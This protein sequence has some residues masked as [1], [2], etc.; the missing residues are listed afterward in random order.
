[1]LKQRRSLG[2][3][4]GK[5]LAALVIVGLWQLLTLIVSGIELP[6]AREIVSLL[7]EPGNALWFHGLISARRILVSLGIALVLA[8]PLGM[9]LGRNLEVDRVVGPFI[10]LTYPVPKLVFLPLVFVLLGLGDSSRVLLI[11]MTVFFQIL[12]TTRDAARSLPLEAVYSIRSLGGGRL[13]FYRHVLFPYCLPKVFTA[14]RISVGTASSVLFFAESFAT[15]TGL[16]YLIMDSWGQFDYALM[17]AAI[18]AMS[19]LGLV[20]YSVIEV[21]EARI[22]AWSR[23]GEVR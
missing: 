1:M 4:S 16:G 18:V 7:F 23:L 3:F 8:V 21:L 9:Y 17:M 22:C 2:G 10:Y 6:S 11:T 15:S 13:A 14:L 19:L 5:L 12:V 20:L